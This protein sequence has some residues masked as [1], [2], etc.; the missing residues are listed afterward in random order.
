M[1]SLDPH[2]YQQHYPKVANRVDAWQAALLRVPRTEL[3]RAWTREVPA[4]R[5]RRMALTPPPQ[6]LAPVGHQYR[7]HRYTRKDGFPSLYLSDGVSTV[8]AEV[9]GSDQV[10][11]GSLGTPDSSR[12]TLRVETHLPDVVDLTDAG[13]RDDLRVTEEDLTEEFRPLEVDAMGR[14]PGYELP[15]CL[16]E[17]AHDLKI[18]AFRYP[19]AP[20]RKAGFA[21]MNVVIFVDNLAA[22]GGWYQVQDPVTGEIE[23]WPTPP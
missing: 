9:F 8:L 6:L 2:K 14:F 19:S 12:L 5:L 23:R 7:H 1:S 13:V 15:Q 20:A 3:H 21:G 11:S 22:T 17:L 16:G 18:G 4:A 10:R